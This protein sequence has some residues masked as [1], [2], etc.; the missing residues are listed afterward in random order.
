[1][2]EGEVQEFA[3]KYALQNAVQHGGRAQPRPVLGKLLSSLP[4]LRSDVKALSQIVDEVVEEVNKLSLSEQ[5]KALEEQWPELLVKEKGKREERVLPPLPNVEKYPLV[6]TRFSPNPDGA[7]HLGGARAA[8]L[9]DEYRRMYN[10]RMTL[11]FDD[12]DPRIK[13]PIPEAYDWIREDLRW[14]GVEWQSEAY[15]SSRMEIYYAYAERL[16][17]IGAAYV[18]TCEPPEF[19]KRLLTKEACPCR[20]L[21]P[22]EQLDRWRKMLDGTYKEGEAV[23]RIKTDLSHPNPAVRE[24]PALRIIDTVRHP[25]PRNGSRYPVWPLFAFC[26]G[27]DDHDLQISH[28]LRG[29]E[30]LTNAVRMQF[31]YKHLGWETPEAVH[32]GRMKI[33]GSVLSKSKI[34]AGVRDGAYTGWDDPRL[35]T[36]MALR[37]RGYLPEAIR[38]LMVELGPK[39]VDITLSWDNLDAIN[40]KLSD[41]VANRYFFVTNPVRLTVEEIE[42]R[43]ICTPLLH[44][45][46]PGRGHRTLVVEPQDGRAVLMV[47]GEDLKLLELDRL[48]RLMGLFN[49]EVKKAGMEGVVAR[50]HSEPYSEAKNIGM[51]LIHWL[52]ENGNVEVRV[53]MPTSQVVEGL[54]EHGLENEEVNSIV[55]MERFGFGRIDSK[56]AGQILLYYAHR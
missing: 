26:C 47:S 48:V 30:H 54:G 40:R 39:P 52:P 25:H 31:L 24:W 20:E 2:R 27:I 21:P 12:S 43:Y 18:C 32:Y 56:S 9:C 6:H 4:E 35:G 28:I 42:S 44:P 38:R 13:S 53:V 5:T 14:L 37:R 49:V 23:I 34:K 3:K 15:Q 7:L 55:Q 22:E 45:D 1:M 17:R 50:F 11:R 16:F 36:L 29:K 33:R 51:R 8:I 41:R 46:Y 19:R 10:G